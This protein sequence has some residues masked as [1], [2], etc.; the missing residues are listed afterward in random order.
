MGIGFHQL[1]RHKR[2]P[3]PAAKRRLGGRCPEGAERGIGA[4]AFADS[5]VEIIYM[6]GIPVVMESFG[7]EFGDSAAFGGDTDRAK[8]FALPAAL[9]VIGEEA[10]MGIDAARVEITENVVSIGPRAFA[11]CEKLTALVIPATVESI[12][13]TALAGSENVTVYGEAD[14]EAQRF[15]EANSIPFVPA[16]TKPAPVPQGALRAPVVMPFVAFN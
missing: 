16:N 13:D 10:F 12:D 4:S 9:A 2:L 3:P 7:L 11:D 5:G 8:S 1:T 15:A 6:D 14:S